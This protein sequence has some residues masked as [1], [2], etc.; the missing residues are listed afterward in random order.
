M[1]EHMFTTASFNEE[2]PAL[3]VEKGP[4]QGLFSNPFEGFSPGAEVVTE[5]PKIVAPAVSRVDTKKVVDDILKGMRSV[6]IS[7]VS[8]V[9]KEAVRQT[10]NAAVYLASEVINALKT[11][12]IQAVK[13]AA[14]KF[15]IELCA[16]TIRK[17]VETMFSLKMT[18]PNIDTEGVYY[19]IQGAGK[20]TGNTP[21]GNPTHHHVPSPS[22]SNP[23][24]NGSMFAP[25]TATW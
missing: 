13:M 2:I 24:G 7:T 15:G 11:M 21:V 22:F 25:Q 14:F 5:Q 12:F 17:L 1:Q 16:M 10:A 6:P 9:S 19:N 4:G 23:F 20:T 8:Y 3:E 18:P